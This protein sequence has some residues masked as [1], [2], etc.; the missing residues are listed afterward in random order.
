MKSMTVAIDSRQLEAFVYVM[1]E[2]DSLGMLSQRYVNTMAEGYESAGF[3]LS[4][5]ENAIAETE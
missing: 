3:D 4:V 5:L 1:M 2:G